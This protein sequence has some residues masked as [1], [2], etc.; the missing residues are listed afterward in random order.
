MRVLVTGAQGQVGTELISRG[1][2]Q[3]L[4]MIAAGRGELD[5][6]AEE[7]VSACF[8][9][10]SPDIVINAAAYTAVDKAEQESALANTI[11]R[12]GPALLAKECARRNIPLLHISTDYVFDGTKDGAYDEDDRPNPQGVYGKSKL[13]GEKAV[14]RTLEQHV[15]LRVAWVFGATGGNFVR[16][17]LRLGNE[18]DELNVVADQRGGPTWAGDIASVLLS[19]VERYHKG[20]AIPWGTYHYIGKPVTTWHGFAQ[21]IF[22][23]A[24]AEGMLEKAPGINAITTAEYSTPAVRPK[25]SVLDCRKIERLLGISQPDWRFGLKSVL[26]NWKATSQ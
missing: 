5:I 8:N 22:D 2:E 13:E 11:N 10:S 7:A 26:E 19:I 17:M 9:G 12:D 18:R 24:M 21:A 6:T 15:I 14:E 4:R 1:R 3:G 25:N 23:A 20:G 16:T